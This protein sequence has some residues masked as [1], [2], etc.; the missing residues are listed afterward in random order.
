M[1]VTDAFI[2]STC[3]Y[4]IYKVLFFFQPQLHFNKIKR[5]YFRKLVN[6]MWKLSL[7]L[8]IIIGIACE[9]NTVKEND[10]LIESKKSIKAALNIIAS[11][12]IVDTS[13]LIPIVVTFNQIMPLITEKDT[14]KMDI[15]EKLQVR[16]IWKKGKKLDSDSISII[17]I[18]EIV[19]VFLDNHNDTSKA[20]V[21]IG[22]VMTTGGKGYSVKN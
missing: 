6:S 9:S 4:L 22:P 19:D 17:T 15:E 12:E 18:W 13:K 2:V 10:S 1:F 7:F 21:S 11:R 16:F 8:I 5:T 3:L 14:I 20:T